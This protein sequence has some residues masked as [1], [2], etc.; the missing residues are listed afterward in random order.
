MLISYTDL[1]L[2]ISELNAWPLPAHPVKATQFYT[3]KTIDTNYIHTT[4]DLAPALSKHGQAKGIS[5]DGSHH[6]Y[7][8]ESAI[9]RSS[10]YPSDYS[11]E[12]ARDNFGSCFFQ[13]LS[14]KDHGSSWLQDIATIRGIAYVVFEEV[15][16]LGGSN[17]LMAQSH[18]EF[19]RGREM[20][21]SAV[22]K[23]MERLRIRFDGINFSPGDKQR[24][25]DALKK[26]AG[27]R[28]REEYSQCLEILID[29]LT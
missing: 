3:G 20:I 7:G 24:K 19:L 2:R 26:L 28:V 4:L 18:L 21:A 29:R 27:A 13:F 10:T 9:S 15:R 12:A 14:E 25:I 5:F 17:K 1:P 11:R 8:F 23:A 6:Q 22:K 16:R